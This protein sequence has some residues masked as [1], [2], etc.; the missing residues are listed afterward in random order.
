[1]SDTRVLSMFEKKTIVVMCKTFS[2][3]RVAKTFGVSAETVSD[4]I[5]SG[6]QDH[7]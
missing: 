2:V 1:M 5:K 6:V 4:L 3:R 7:G